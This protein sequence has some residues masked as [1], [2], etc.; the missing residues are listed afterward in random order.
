M[1]SLD[2]R[3]ARDGRFQNRARLVHGNSADSRQGVP[4]C[5]VMVAT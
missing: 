4:G 1:I 2:E 5:Q 3:L